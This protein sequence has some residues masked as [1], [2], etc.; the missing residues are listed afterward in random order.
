[1]PFIFQCLAAKNF[2][3]QS[4]IN[5]GE[6]KDVVQSKIAETNFEESNAP[7]SMG[8]EGL[9][10]KEEEEEIQIKNIIYSGRDECEK[11][12]INKV[13]DFKKEPTI[14][15]EE[16]KGANSNKVLPVPIGGIQFRQMILII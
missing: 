5:K 7:L 3:I 11:I 2:I 10:L 4:I 6:K 14:S 12:N 15:A 1:M 16:G 8:K 13:K 9:K